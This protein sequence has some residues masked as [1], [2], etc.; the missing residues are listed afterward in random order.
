MKAI[1]FVLLVGCASAKQ[2]DTLADS[3]REY[4]DGVRWERFGVAANHVPPKERSA[5]VDQVDER[6]KD[7]KITDYDVVKMDAKGD[8]AA[9]VQIKLSWYKESEGTLRETQAVQSWER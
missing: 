8:S 6:S 9:T 5:F 3:V 7:V 2:G 1:W 4:N